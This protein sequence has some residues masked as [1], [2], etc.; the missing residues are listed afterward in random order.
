MTEQ[1]GFEEPPVFL[2]VFAKPKGPG[3]KEKPEEEPPS[4]EH[5]L[6]FDTE[7]T[8]D[9]WQNLRFGIAREYALGHLCRTIAFTGLVTEIEEGKIAE[10]AKVNHAEVFT[11]DQFVRE[12]FLPIALDMRAAVVG[13]NL[14]FDLARLAIYWEPNDRPGGKEHWTLWFVPRGSSRSAYLPRL[15]VQRVDSTKGF[16]AFAG[17][18][19]RWRKY[20]GAF[21]DVRTFVHVLTG[22]KHSLESAGV[23]FGCT[24]KKT[25]TD[26][27]GPVD[28][29]YLDYT[30]T[31][32]ALTAE[33][34]EKC[35]AR[36]REFGIGEHPSRLYS[37]ASLAK[38]ALRARAIVPPRLAHYWTGRIMCGFYA[39][40]VECR[41][42]GRE[43]ADV[44]VLD[45]TSEFPSLYCLL[46]ADRFLTARQ[47]RTRR[48]TEQVRAWLD[49]LTLADLLRPE[50]WGTPLMW[51]LCEVEARGEIL[52]VR[53]TYT[54]D[55]SQPPTIGWNHVT[56]EEGV[57][58]PYLVPD[59]IAAKLLCGRVPKIVRATTFEPVG[60]QAVRPLTLLG[61]EVAVDE[62]LVRKS[63]EARIREKAGKKLGWEP[64]AQGLKILSNALA[65][66]IFVEV[67]RKRKAGTSTIYGLDE[68]PFEFE[69][70]ETEVPGE[71]HCPLLG[72]ILTSA[73]H[74][75]LAL[76]ETVVKTNGG[77][78][79]YEDTDSVFVT[80]SRVVQEV[81][82]VFDSLNP[83]A[84]P[85]HFLK[86]EAEEKAPRG[87]YPKGSPDSQ[88]RFFGLSCKRYCL[89]VRD[90]QGRPHVFRKAASDHG[91]GSFEVSGN[92]KEFIASV[93]EAIIENG[94]RAGDRFAGIPA[95]SPFALSTPMLLPRVRELGP[96]PPFT[97]MTA[98]FLEPSSDPDKARSELIPFISTKDVAAR[99]ALMLLPRQRSWGSVVEAF[100]RHRDRKCTFDSDGRMVR[101]LVLVR[102]SRIQG[103]GKEANRI[104]SARVLG[105]GPTGARAKV[106]IPWA[107]R[108]LALPL[109]WAT[110]HGIDKRNFARLR[111]RL[112]KGKIARGYRGG[113]L[114]NVQGILAQ[115]YSRQA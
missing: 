35:L 70:T 69:D 12:I 5:V 10:W 44:A 23:A 113:L 105:V 6:V 18:K 57:T 53:S 43:A 65:Y 24:L 27:H 86:D 103:L 42:V 98:R 16:I 89:F 115:S 106:Y 71:D 26:Y 41:V 84:I 54:G 73:S 63:S 7:T 108:I 88:P 66:G 29:R 38:A 85:T 74:L 99:D 39:G 2:R 51:S 46:G 96:I 45:F 87:E 34:Y 62:D 109:S 97:F 94:P 9:L 79:V 92:R 47:V 93:W 50:T 4:D 78:V 58:L 76:A 83:Y 81:T 77:E 61:V 56:T 111:R 104:E 68:E 32:V 25:K 22:E 8:T 48:S 20:R 14:P 17:T 49:S 80:P 33:L 59:L 28:A 91:L 52:P 100:A 55:P 114:S 30:L 60:R 11:V 75:L 40:K 3:K 95:T 82:E 102:D 67:N 110:E 107:E 112:R 36:Y 13:F 64:R 21:V 19:G 37:P 90:R 31:D 1:P 72:A 101:R 15:R